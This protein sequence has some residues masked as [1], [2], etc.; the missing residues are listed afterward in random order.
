MT[1]PN[2]GFLSD[3]PLFG[4]TVR[5]D[6]IKV[7]S[8][9]GPYS[10]F[11]FLSGR[12]LFRFWQ[13]AMQSVLALNYP[14]H[15]A[16]CCLVWSSWI[17]YLIVIVVYYSSIIVYGDFPGFWR[18]IIQIIWLV[19]CNIFWK[20]IASLSTKNYLG[21]NTPGCTDRVRLDT[22]QLM[23]WF[24]SL[25]SPHCTGWLLGTWARSQLGVMSKFIK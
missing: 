2:S 22:I 5:L 24:G 11:R 19:N 25:V 18:W 20:H 17:I 6:P 15:G 7:F 3:R 14:L 9:A 10:G 4:L 16:T 21:H 23:G 8:L 12:P 13:S 1:A